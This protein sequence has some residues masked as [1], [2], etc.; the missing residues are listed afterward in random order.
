M[1]FKVSIAVDKKSR[2]RIEPDLEQNELAAIGYVTAQWAFLEHAILASTVEIAQTNG[3]RIPVGASSKAFSK[4][5]QAWQSMIKKF[6]TNPSHQSVLL[7]TAGKAANLAGKRHKLAHALWSWDR[8]DPTALRAFSFRPNLEFDVDF[9]YDGLILLGDKIGEV[10]FDL[11]FPGGAEDAWK[12]VFESHADKDGYV[13]YVSGSF[14]L[15]TMGKAPSGRHRPRQGSPLKRKR[16][17]V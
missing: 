10:N 12:S 13:N 3:V 7:R 11:V 14:L 1:S 6:I 17:G 9:D 2:H 15:S 8:P 4:R 16:T 5:L